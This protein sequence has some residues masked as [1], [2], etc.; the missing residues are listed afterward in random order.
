MA[1]TRATSINSAVTPAKVSGS[2][3]RTP[4]SWL[5]SRGVSS[6]ANPNPS[7]MPAPANRAACA[8]TMRSTD[9]GSAPSARRSPI[10]RVRSPTTRAITP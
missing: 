2:P 3:G 6:H 7:V 9:D 1:A 10:S 4:Y 8:T 5:V